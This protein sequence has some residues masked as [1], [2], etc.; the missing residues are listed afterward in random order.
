MPDVISHIQTFRDYFHYHIK[1]SKAY[2]H[3]RMR[4]RTA[5]FLQGKVN[6]TAMA[7]EETNT[8][9]FCDGLDRTARSIRSARRRVGG[10]SGLKGANRTLMMNSVLFVQGPARSHQR[11]YNARTI[12]ILLLLDS[13]ESI[14]IVQSFWW[15]ARPVSWPANFQ[16]D[17]SPYNLLDRHRSYLPAAQ[18]HCITRP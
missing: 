8:L 4:R 6:L 17:S 2:I 3:S 11:C 9:Q 15:P 7:N 5:D 16:F 18:Q 13:N 12:L 14:S 1:A 10:P